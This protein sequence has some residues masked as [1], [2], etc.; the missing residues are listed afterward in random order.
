VRWFIDGY[1]VI[2]RD[3]ELAGLDQRSLSDGREALL[4]LL[5]R[6]ARDSGDDFVVVFDGA[7]GGHPPMPAGRVR[8][9]FSRP[10]EKADDVL[11]RLA[12]AGGDGAT[13][14]SSDRA[15][16]DASRRAH[17]AAVGADEFLAHALA[18]A[19]PPDR[20]DA[21]D[22]PRRPKTGNPRRL[23]RAE[24]RSR[25]ALDRLRRPRP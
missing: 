5:A 25:R 13:V 3:P 2:R 9:I 8:V 10:P 24:R 19:A 23:K 18:G 4:R 20:D 14:V 7:R 16:Q 17:A 15:V 6:V 21:E 1:N 22:E 12:R 11:V